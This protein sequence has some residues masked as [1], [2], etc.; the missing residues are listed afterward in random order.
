MKFRVLYTPKAEKDLNALPTSMATRIKDKMDWFVA[1][2]DPLHFAK[3]LHHT[4]RAL[5]R[6][7]VGDYR[8]ICEDRNG[9]IHI[10]VVLTV[11]HRKEIYR[12]I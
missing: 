2:E 11:G 12:S 8:I 9:A 4:D 1:Q 3:S 5:F 6:F 7:R 10:L